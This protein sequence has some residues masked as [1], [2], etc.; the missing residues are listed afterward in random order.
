MRT[1]FIGA[2]PGCRAVLELYRQRRLSFLNLDIVAV[3]DL[4]PDAPGMRF[5][6]AHGWPT[7]TR[8]EDAL[9]AE[10]L[11]L[12]IELTGKNE[13][14]E[15]IYRL[16]PHGV[17]VMDHG[18]ARV[19]WDLDE[20]VSNLQ[21]ELRQR[22]ELERQAERERDWLQKILDS[23]PDAV[24]VLDRDRR[25]ERVNRRVEQWCGISRETARGRHCYEV[26]ADVDEPAHCSQG[27]CPFK[28]VVESGLPI[29]R[30]RHEDGTRL[31]EGYYQVTANPVFDDEGALTH[32]VETSREITERVML[33][34][35]LLQSERLAAVG[36][37]AA[38]V[39]HELNNP[40]TGILTYA[41]DLLEDA[42]AVDRR[43]PDYELIVHEA[44]RCRRIV[45]DLLDFSRQ[46]APHLKPAAL[47]PV[48]ERTVTMVERQ[49]PFHDVALKLDLATALPPIRIDDAQIQQ[50]ILNLLING[51]DAMDGRG[52]LMVRTGFV[53]E[54]RSVEIAVSDTG[55]GIPTDQQS[56]V[57]EPFFSTKG[58]HGNGLGLPAVVGVMEQHGGRVEL[59]SEV[60]VGSTFRLILPA[61]EPPGE[62][63]A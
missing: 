35:E 27:S 29:T 3:A 34:R 47:N 36:K 30:E 44:L 1:A 40:L 20:V 60:G 37:L 54:G 41:E 56:Q 13:V 15:H 31:P 46:K 25:V 51:R 8:L 11:E 12:V 53:D 55:C 62:E 49:V 43:R 2:G 24:M 26:C 17:R 50:A 57:F 39:A 33:K 58:E 59:D 21:L 48:V 32:V 10:G 7:F 19:F 28:R 52:E 38:G 6:R 45:R 16:L 14:I 61:A 22:T 18:L 23:L 42:D 9:A 63:G 5:A 4:D